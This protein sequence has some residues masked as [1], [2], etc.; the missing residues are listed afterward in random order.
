MKHG[1]GLFGTIIGIG[2]ALLGYGTYKLVTG[3][4]AGTEDEDCDYEVV[5]EEEA[6]EDEDAE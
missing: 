5:D 2:A 6:E 4:N 3:K 1:K